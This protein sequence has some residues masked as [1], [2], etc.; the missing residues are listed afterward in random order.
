MQKQQSKLLNQNLLRELKQLHFHTKKLVD[1]GISGRYKS[2]FRGKGIEFEELR[3]YQP[4]DDIRSIDWKVTARSRKPYI[5]SYR[6]ERELNVVIAVDVS[7]STLAGTK[8]QVR[9]DTIAKVGAALT[10]IALNNND[11]VGLITF[12][13]HVETYFPPRKARSAVWRIL[14][15]VLTPEETPSFRTNLN[16]VFSF[17]Y[18]ILKRRSVIFIISDFLDKNYEKS[19]AILAKKHDVTAVVISDPSDINIPTIGLIN[20]LDPESGESFLLDTSSPEFKKEFDSRVLSARQQLKE[21]L[22]RHRIGTMEINSNDPYM[23]EIRKFFEGK[24]A[25]QLKTLSI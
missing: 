6:E 18:S 23:P 20:C 10:L 21:I 12:S 25:H 5:K 11:K 1:S 7:R 22:V 16:R 2:A 24:I 19:L 15:Q 3:E 4:G 9:E 17:L 13:D 14:H 8:N